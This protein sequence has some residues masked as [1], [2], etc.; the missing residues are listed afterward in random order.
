MKHRE[1]IFAYHGIRRLLTVLIT[2]TI[3]YLIFYTIAHH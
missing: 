2:G 3:C 1:P